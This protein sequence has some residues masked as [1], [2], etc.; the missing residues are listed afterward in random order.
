MCCGVGSSPQSGVVTT[1]TEFFWQGMHNSIVSAVL[2]MHL[3]LGS[4]FVSIVKLQCF[5]CK[6][7]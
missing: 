1:H 7:M 3:G 4:H 5:G 2:L 6:A